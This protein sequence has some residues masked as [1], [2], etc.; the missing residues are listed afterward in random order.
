MTDELITA[1][2][3]LFFLAGYETTSRSISLAL[4]ELA[5]NTKLQDKLKN[6]IN[7]YW[8]KYDGNITYEMVNSMPYLNQVVLGENL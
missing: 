6:E 5:A 8:Q 1:N 4:Y 7:D 2:C 3:F